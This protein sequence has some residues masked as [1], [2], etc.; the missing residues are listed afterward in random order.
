MLFTEFL[1]SW[2][3]PD[4]LIP[5]SSQSSAALNLLLPRTFMYSSVRTICQEGS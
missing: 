5:I 1:K 2:M 3:K 4:A